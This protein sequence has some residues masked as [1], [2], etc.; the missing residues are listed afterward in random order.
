MKKITIK[1]VAKQAGVSIGTVSRVFNGYTDIGEATKQKVLR[2]ADELEY[3]PNLSARSL[4]SKKKRNI[5]LLLNNLELNNKANLSMD[6]LSG[7]YQYTQ[8]TDFEFFLIPITTEQQKEKS[9]QKF[10]NERDISGAVI[11]GLKTDDPYIKEIEKSS[12]PIV[13]VDIEIAGDHVGSVSVDNEQA[14]YEAVEH[15]L[16]LGHE[17]IALMNGRKEAK[18]TVN[19]E[20]GYRKA[21]KERQIEVRQ[22]LIQYA[23][24]SE[25]IAQMMALD[26]LKN[27][28]DLTA[29]FCASDIMAIGVMKAIKETG[30]TIPE[31]ISVVGFDDITLAQYLTPPLST[32]TQNMKDIGYQAATLLSRFILNEEIE[33]QHIFVPHV[34]TIRETTTER[35]TKSGALR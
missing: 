30:K 7:V 28:P 1:D 15:L 12:I 21:L 23:N 25:D 4:S 10:L 17:H 13:L 14:A 33:R 26:L 20:A 19:R 9:L 27:Y 22:E 24:F 18:V 8:E 32:V 3:T 6:I 31:D 29:F 11:Q 34:L 5:A 16:S 35:K 2:I